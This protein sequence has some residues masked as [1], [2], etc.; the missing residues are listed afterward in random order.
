MEKSNVDNPPQK[1]K[2]V[3]IVNPFCRDDS[4]PL[5]SLLV[6]KID[7]GVGYM[8]LPRSVKVYRQTNLRF[9]LFGILGN[10]GRTMFL[11][12]LCHLQTDR[13][14]INLNNKKVCVD[15]GVCRSVVN[16]G[17]AELIKGRFIEKKKNRKGIFWVN[18][19]YMFMGN[20][21]RY[22]DEQEEGLIDIYGK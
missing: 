6:R 12:I 1:E 8:D 16:R 7:G 9:L 3:A 11:Y 4:F 22:Y 2:I 15:L 18:P 20:R 14:W 10:N 13:D 17:I 5:S 19:Y 21:K